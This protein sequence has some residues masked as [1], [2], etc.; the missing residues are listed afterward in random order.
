MRKMY[1]AMIPKRSALETLLIA[2]GVGAGLIYGSKKLLG[3]EK[4]NEYKAQLK[5]K[6]YAAGAKEFDPVEETAAQA[7]EAEADAAASRESAILERI[8][9]ASAKGVEKIL[10]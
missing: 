3:E 4:F 10:G 2:A 6:L 1:F 5:N 7:E 8:K 9:R